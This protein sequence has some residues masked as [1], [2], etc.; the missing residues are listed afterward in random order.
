MK[1]KL[2]TANGNVNFV[3]P[4]KAELITQ[5]KVYC[6]E[7]NINFSHAI[8][9]AHIDA[10]NNIP[11]KPQKK[12]GILD[13]FNGARAVLRY[14][15]GNS[16]TPEEVLRRAE[17]CKTCPML[18]ATTGCASCGA[19]G[20]IARYINAIRVFK[21]YESAIPKEVESKYC[22]VCSCSIPMMIVTHYKD[23]YKESESKNSARPDHCWLKRTSENFTDE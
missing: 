13:A 7:N 4:T 2:R 14:A 19:G 1:F 8:V 12:V 9:S 15:A 16:A 10:Q 5:V 20:R 21:K 6:H 18:K 22:D 3:A 17:I 23:F 11:T